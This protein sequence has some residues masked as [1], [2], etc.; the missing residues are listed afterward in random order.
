MGQNLSLQ[1]QVPVA[2]D[3]E[4]EVVMFR[5]IPQSVYLNS[6]ETHSE[7]EGLG[8]FRLESIAAA[9]GM[10]AV[11]TS[12]T[13]A[14]LHR[15]M[16]RYRYTAACLCLV[17]DQPGGSVGV[18]GKGRPKIQYSFTQKTLDNVKNA[19]VA[20]ARAY[21]AAGARAVI[22]PSAG[23]EIVLNLAELNGLDFQLRQGNTPYISAHPQGTCRMGP[24][25]ERSVVGL[26]LRVHGL[27]N[28][29]V[30]DASIFPTSASTHTMLPVMSYAWLGAR[31]L[32]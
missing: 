30:L 25:R 14:A 20:A 28:L 19:V 8:G 29:Q 7:A 26:D 12:L 1:P 23:A 32:L 17:P 15:F 31:G 4:D 6:G 10:A 3:F 2:A 27:A 9:P 22:L 13:G 5:G 11:S 16:T 21:L 24:D 18:D